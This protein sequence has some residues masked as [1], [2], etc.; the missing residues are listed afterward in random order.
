MPERDRRTNYLMRVDRRAF[1][2]LT[3]QLVQEKRKAARHEHWFHYYR[4]KKYAAS[5]L[6]LL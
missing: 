3:I 5:I 2:S 6:Q 4:H 1:K